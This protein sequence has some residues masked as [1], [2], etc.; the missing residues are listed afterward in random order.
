M[1]FKGPGA[2]ARTVLSLQRELDLE[3]SWGSEN[4]R[5]FNVFFGT[6]KN[7]SVF[8]LIQLAEYDAWFPFWTVTVQA[9]LAHSSKLTW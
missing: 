1:T 9:C 6:R 8:V 4:D 5:F 3:C 2:H 7:A